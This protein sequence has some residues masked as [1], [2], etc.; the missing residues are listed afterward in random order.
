MTMRSAGVVA[1]LVDEGMTM[2]VGVSVLE[3][4]NVGVE[5][6]VDTIGVVDAVTPIIT[7]VGLKI[8]GVREGGKKGV[9]GLLGSG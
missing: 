9:G 7:G 6:D 5:V 1:R 8:T 3:G 4:K 2:S